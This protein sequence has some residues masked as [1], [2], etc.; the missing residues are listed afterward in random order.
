M[1]VVRSYKCTS[2][3]HVLASDACFRHVTQSVTSSEGLIQCLEI[4]RWKG[5]V[6]CTDVIHSYSLVIRNNSSVNNNGGP[7]AGLSSPRIHVSRT[8]MCAST[9]SQFSGSNYR[10]CE[11]RLDSAIQSGAY[12]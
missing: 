3:V 9:I 11:L 5:T 8:G 2:T 1:V 4:A 10:V 6:L 12:C 7:L